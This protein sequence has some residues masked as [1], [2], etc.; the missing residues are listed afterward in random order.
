MASSTKLKLSSTGLF[1]WLG[2][3]RKENPLDPAAM[4]TSGTYFLFAALKFMAGA[5]AFIPPAAPGMFGLVLYIGM[6]LE[7]GRPMPI[8]CG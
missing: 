5:C 7:L 1:P 4:F 8:C 3:P 2:A 6:G